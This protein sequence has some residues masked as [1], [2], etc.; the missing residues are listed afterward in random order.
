MATPETLLSEHTYSK[1]LLSW[2]THSII[3]SSPTQ[4][5]RLITVPRSA[6][7][8]VHKV[9]QYFVLIYSIYSTCIPSFDEPINN[10]MI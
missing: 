5:A 10:A 8:K 6:F 7:T 4:Q 2:S 1:G 3:F 9:F